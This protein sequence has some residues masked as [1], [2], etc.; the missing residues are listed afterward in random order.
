MSATGHGGDGRGNRPA[1]GIEDSTDPGPERRVHRGGQ[2]GAGEGDL[3][4]CSR[5]ERAGSGAIAR[6]SAGSLRRRRGRRQPRRLPVHRHDRPDVLRAGLRHRPDQHRRRAV[7][8]RQR[9]LASLGVRRRRACRAAQLQPV[10]DAGSRRRAVALHDAQRAPRRRR[11]LPR[12]RPRCRRRRRDRRDPA[13]TRTARPRTAA[14]PGGRPAHRGGA[15]G[16]APERQAGDMAPR[17]ARHHAEEHRQGRRAAREGHVRAPQGPAPGRQRTCA[18][19]AA[20]RHPSASRCACSAT[21]RQALRSR[22]RFPDHADEATAP[23]GTLA[24]QRD[25]RVPWG[26]RL[27]RTGGQLRRHRLQPHDLTGTLGADEHVPRRPDHGATNAA[28]PRSVP[29][30]EATPAPC[31]PRTFSTRPRTSPRARAPAGRSPRLRGRRSPR[32]ATTAAYPR[33]RART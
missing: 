9:H 32:S 22:S 31:T 33:T 2:P 17:R 3:H 15:T 5:G 21:A 30:T 25:R 24:R 28:D 16:T 12:R 1:A 14:V 11:R 4:P 7:L 8:L 10:H 18:C 20:R 23:Q 19:V 6:Q 29:S 26:A 27:S 13:A